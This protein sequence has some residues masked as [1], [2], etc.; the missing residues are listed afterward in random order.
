MD[1][2]LFGHGECFGCGLCL[3][4]CPLWRARRDIR[5]SAQGCA[6][7]LQ[8]GA[9]T[10]ELAE[11]VDSCCLCGACEPA[12]PAQIGL[13]A[14]IADLRAELA[15]RDPN[16]VAQVQE[17]MNARRDSAPA[18]SP[19]AVTLVPD[20]A[21]NANGTLLGRVAALLGE[22]E[23][24]ALAED[25]GADIALALEAGAA[26]PAARLARF[27]A[28]LARA[29]RII[30]GDGML[31]RALRSWLPRTPVET[32]G[33]AMSSLRAVRGKL[34]AADLY[35]IEPRAY[36]A[37]H[38]RL[39]KHYDGLRR[40]RGCSMNLDLQRLAIPTAA[41]SLA[42][43]LGRSKV[44]ARDQA[45]WILEGAPECSRIVVEDLQDIAAF[46]AVTGKPVVHL[47]Q[48]T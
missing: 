18:A 42:A 24:L 5:L 21:L 34:R 36:H 26:I 41:G 46:T 2:R 23:K 25:D 15:R 10:E 4:A 22:R 7:A 17:Q 35:V 39:V 45:R 16:R 37:D 32:L 20:E 12:C 43:I 1:D 8:C 31:F 11:A 13:I 29:R 47:A 19:A 40:E 28:P 27:L 30:T 38:A 48:V 6:R 33:A 3:L 14:M 9:G 44:D